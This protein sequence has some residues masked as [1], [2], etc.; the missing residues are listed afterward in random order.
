MYNDNVKR[1]D[2][3]TLNKICTVLECDISDI[4]EFVKD[5]EVAQ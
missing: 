2:M 5:E 1:L 3:A 4:L